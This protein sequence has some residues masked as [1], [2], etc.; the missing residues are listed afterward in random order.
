MIT[1]PVLLRV[2]RKVARC[3]LF[4]FRHALLLLLGQV[5]PP[6]AALFPLA[7]TDERSFLSTRQNEKSNKLEGQLLLFTVLVMWKP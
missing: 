1:L 3:S 5:D 6:A 7:A 2:L 4:H